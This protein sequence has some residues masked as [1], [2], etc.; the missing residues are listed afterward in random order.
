MEEGDNE[1]DHDEPVVANIILPNRPHYTAVQVEEMGSFKLESIDRETYPSHEDGSASK[2][3]RQGIIDEVDSDTGEHTSTAFRRTVMRNVSIVSATSEDEQ[4]AMM[5]TGRDIS[6]DEVERNV[7][8]E[9]GQSQIRYTTT[10]IEEQQVVEVDE[11]G[12]VGDEVRQNT[13]SNIET[14]VIEPKEALEASV[15][16]TIDKNNETNDKMISTAEKPKAKKAKV[17]TV[18]SVEEVEVPKELTDEELR[19]QRIKDI[20]SRARKGSLCSKE[21]STETEIDDSL[22]KNP[23]EIIVSKTPDSA[24]NLEKKPITEIPLNWEGDK[25]KESVIE[26]K[27]HTSQIDLSNIS[28]ETA[29]EEDPFMA[30]LLRRGQAQRAALQKILSYKGNSSDLHE[31]HVHFEDTNTSEE[32][33]NQNLVNQVS[34]ESD[35]EKVSSRPIQFNDKSGPGTHS[36][37]RLP[38]DTH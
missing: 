9:N 16:I 13:S 15:K 6:I 14:N 37:S 32:T 20:R 10:V 17:W 36:I 24:K 22:A 34:N 21:I 29:E 27:D 5:T 19:R 25:L 2:T 11:N 31:H 38:L 35:F 30:A 28:H 23:I 4:A 1:F 18:E 33:S 8:F 26:H 7:V 12:V 3:V